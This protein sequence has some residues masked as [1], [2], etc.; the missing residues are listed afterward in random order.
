[1]ATGCRQ[2]QSE[3][4]LEGSNIDFVHRLPALHEELPGDVWVSLTISATTLLSVDL[5]PVVSQSS[6]RLVQE[7][8]E[9]ESVTDDAG[10]I[11]AVGRPATSDELRAAGGV[12]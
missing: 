2:L 9:H 11:A 3:H 1:M 6:R 8:T 12:L 4:A 7:I 5:G 10:V